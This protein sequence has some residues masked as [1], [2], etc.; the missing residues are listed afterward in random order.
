MSSTRRGN[1]RVGYRYSVQ[2]QR[3]AVANELKS[4][5]EPIAEEEGYLTPRGRGRPKRKERPVKEIIDI[6]SSNHGSLKTNNNRH[7]EV[8]SPNNHCPVKKSETAFTSAVEKMTSAIS[9]LAKILEI[10]SSPGA[11]FLTQE[12]MMSRLN[13]KSTPRSS[14]A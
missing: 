12:S 6:S 9:S 10:Q 1:G 14:I 11:R 8:N 3:K 2:I 7:D 13:T 4:H 5:L